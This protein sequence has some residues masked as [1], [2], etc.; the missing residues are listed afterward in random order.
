MKVF[1]VPL[2]TVMFKELEING[3]NQIEI[4]NNNQHL[5]LNV[6]PG[7]V[8]ST[9]GTDT[10]VWG[11]FCRAK[12]RQA[13]C[14]V[15]I[16]P[17]RWIGTSQNSYHCISRKWKQAGFIW[18]I[19]SPRCLGPGSCRAQ[20][21]A[22]QPVL[23]SEAGL[24]GSQHQQGTAPL[25]AMWVFAARVQPFPWCLP[26]ALID[27]RAFS[28]CFGFTTGRAGVSALSSFLRIAHCPTGSDLPAGI[29][30]RANGKGLFS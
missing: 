15:I 3:K 28:I 17:W 5:S 9:G 23:R 30:C 4:V 19:F 11:S 6:P 16:W 25:P 22:L 26:M 24:A 18:L 29:K 10:H 7:A 27:F 8:T 2:S 20:A 13:F 14:L 21:L 12:G 1:F